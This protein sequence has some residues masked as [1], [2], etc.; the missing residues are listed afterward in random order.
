MNE[1]TFS[2]RTYTVDAL[3]FLTDSAEW[4]EDFA[5]GMASRA[6]MSGGLTERHWEV[7]RYIR[8]EF[9]DR[10]DCPLVF[11][12]CRS[13]GLSLRELEALFPAGYLRGACR[14]A[15]I[16]Y[17]DRFIDFF[18]ERREPS[19]LRADRRATVAPAGVLPASRE[20]VYRVD[21][22][23]FLVDPTEWDEGFAAHK[24]L[25]MKLPGGLSPGHWQVLEYLRETYQRTGSVPTV[26]GCCGAMGMDLDELEKL[27][28]DGYHR[29]AVKLAGLCVRPGGEL[30]P[31]S[32]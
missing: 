7:I 2:S 11:S 16:S 20:K 31:P 22:M 10:G 13:L 27:F 3:G 1:I 32:A 17:R 21:V 4:D 15:G 29:G 30:L 8:K 19:D 5:E 23:G 26:M 9:R 28:P 24:A 12:T 25:E 6:G 14:L 18:G